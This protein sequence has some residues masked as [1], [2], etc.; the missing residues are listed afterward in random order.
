MHVVT[1]VFVEEANELYCL[2]LCAT[3]LEAVDNV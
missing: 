2:A 1:G 3:L